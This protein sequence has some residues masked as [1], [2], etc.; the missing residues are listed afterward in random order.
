MVTYF[1]T[2]AEQLQ[3]TPHLLL[4]ISELYEEREKHTK[5][6]LL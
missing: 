5:V 6:S 4:Q 1:M 2:D 3:N